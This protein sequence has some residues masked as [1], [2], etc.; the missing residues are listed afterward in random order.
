MARKQTHS[1][2]HTKKNTPRIQWKKNAYHSPPVEGESRREAEDLILRV[3]EVIAPGQF[4]RVVY[5]SN[6]SINAIYANLHLSGSDGL[7]SGGREG[8]PNNDPM[9]HYTVVPQYGPTIHV[10]CIDQAGFFLFLVHFIRKY[11]C[12]DV[13]I[14]FIT[15]DG[16]E[17]S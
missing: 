8:V 12:I 3:A 16:D 6:L 1:N 15:V 17:C 11:T 10:H 4:L 2:F 7:H 13:N 14:H 9:P 5:V